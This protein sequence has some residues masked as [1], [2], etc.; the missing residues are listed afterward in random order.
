MSTGNTDEVKILSLRMRQGCAV[1]D[2][3]PEYLF[4]V[5]GGVR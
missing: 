3:V 1:E 5:V 2:F 4:H